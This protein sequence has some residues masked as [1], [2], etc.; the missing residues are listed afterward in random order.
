MISE[1]QSVLCV[2]VEGHMSKYAPILGNKNIFAH[3][4]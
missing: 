1:N 4:K 3:I 2:C